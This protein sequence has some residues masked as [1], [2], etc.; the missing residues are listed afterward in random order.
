MLTNSL[1]IIGGIWPVLLSIGPYIHVRRRLQIKNDFRT[2]QYPSSYLHAWTQFLFGWAVAVV[3]T[4]IV[5][6]T[7]MWT[8]GRSDAELHR[9]CAHTLVSF[10]FSILPMTLPALAIFLNSTRDPMFTLDLSYGMF[11]ALY[12]LVV[13]N[14]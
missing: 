8:I 11:I 9:I 14:V 12:A 5:I 1:K 2:F 7:G 13:L 10:K 6:A 4:M 3:V